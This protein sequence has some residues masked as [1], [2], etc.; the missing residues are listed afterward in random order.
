MLY[1]GIAKEEQAKQK[2]QKCPDG[3]LLAEILKKRNSIVRQLN[4]IYAIIIANT[5]LAALFLS[6][7]L[8]D[9]EVSI[10]D[11][12]GLSENIYSLQSFL[13]LPKD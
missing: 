1:F 7:A 8:L 2:L 3:L 9:P 6:S 5:A 10:L 13:S 11:N 12:Y 4:N